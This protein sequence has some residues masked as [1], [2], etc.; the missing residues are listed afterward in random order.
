MALVP[1]LVNVL[2]G[3]YTDEDGYDGYRFEMFRCEPHLPAFYL[4]GCRRE[5][6]SRVEVSGHFLRCDMCGLK[7]KVRYANT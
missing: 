1:L 7:R 4:L 2:L 5:I 6:P 3:P